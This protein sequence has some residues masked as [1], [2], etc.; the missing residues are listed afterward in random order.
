MSQK[1]LEELDDLL[2]HL[3]M[4][5]LQL[6]CD[7]DKVVQQLFQPLVMQLIHW[8]TCQRQLRSSHTAIIIETLMVM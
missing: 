7:I 3:A 6:G 1:G 2:K 8:Y 4:P 5:M